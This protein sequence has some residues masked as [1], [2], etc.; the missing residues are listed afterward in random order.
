MKKILFILAFIISVSYVNAYTEYKIGDIVPYND[1]DFY[2]IKNSSSD[3][4]SVTLLKAEPL[5]V[6]E[7]NLY[8]G[9][10]T[11]NNHVNMYVTSDTSASYYQAASNQ[12]G[13]GGM[14]YYTSVDCGNG[15]YSGCITNYADS[16]V[17]YVVD[18]WKNEQAREASEAR[19]ITYNELIGY[20]E[21]QQVCTGSCYETIKLKY[22]WLYNNNYT[23]LTMS[24][25]GDST[26]DVFC[27]RPDGGFGSSSIRNGGLDVVRPVII[28]SK[29]VLVDDDDDD[30]EN[31]IDD[32]TD[33]GNDKTNKVDSN[34][35]ASENKLTVKVDNTYM[36]NSIIIIMIGLISAS[37]SIFILYKLRNKVK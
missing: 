34:N 35:K 7:V 15:L 19:L 25:Y 4:D 21:I 26:M 23:Y 14:V 13:Y 16:E 17:K 10:G 1:M 18:A 37:T 12:N 8:G 31:I 32:D 9:V 33:K 27:V 6:E 29:T 28:L 22:D 24:T 11:A 2:V 20:A 3:E 36:R 30:D 5:S